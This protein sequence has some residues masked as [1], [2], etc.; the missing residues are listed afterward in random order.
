MRS[1]NLPCVDLDL[2]GHVLWGGAG[3][4]GTCSVH[5]PPSRRWRLEAPVQK[6]ALALGEPPLAPALLRASRLSCSKTLLGFTNL[7]RASPR[8]GR[9][10]PVAVPLPPTNT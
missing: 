4:A 5:S 8:L 6:A 7:T 2:A 1:L 3:S 10:P 9:L